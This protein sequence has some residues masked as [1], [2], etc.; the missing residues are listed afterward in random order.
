MWLVDASRSRSFVERMRVRVMITGLLLGST[1]QAFRGAGASM[2]KHVACN[3][4]RTRLG[5]GNMD[6]SEFPD[7][8]EER[9]MDYEDEMMLNEALRKNA[10]SELQIRMNL[11]GFTPLTIAGF[12][13][14]FVIIIL[15]SV[16][17]YGWAS[18]VLGLDPSGMEIAVESDTNNN[19]LRGNMGGGVS[20]QL[21]SKLMEA[22]DELKPILIEN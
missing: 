9:E 16:L 18:E 17:G 5:V 15:N 6:P 4:S 14:A 7:G 11:M 21:D 13:L 2:K 3:L 20:L 10:P 8:M 12:A 22:R 1:C 19:L